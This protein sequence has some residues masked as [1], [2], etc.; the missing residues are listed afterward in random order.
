MS[1][2][3]QDLAGTQPDQKAT[4]P[5]APASTPQSAPQAA[6]TQP[7]QPSSGVFSVNDFATP[8]EQAQQNQP[9]TL[10]PQQE[11]M[12][13]R[14]TRKAQEFVGSMIPQAAMPLMQANQKYLADPIHEFE[15]KIVDMGGEVGRAPAEITTFFQNLPAYLPSAYGQKPS[16]EPIEDAA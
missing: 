2:S 9:A 3:V 5:A 11:S 13:S 7:S 16:V 8:Q 14:M 15:N 1:F 12:L 4:Q 10:P 6:A